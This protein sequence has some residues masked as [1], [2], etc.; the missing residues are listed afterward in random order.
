MI[1]FSNLVCMKLKYFFFYL[2][3]N[4]KIFFQ[5]RNIKE[6]ENVGMIESFCQ[7]KKIGKDIKWN[8]QLIQLSERFY[9]LYIWFFFNCVKILNFGYFKEIFLSVIYCIFVFIL[10]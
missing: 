7:K 9:L 4:L 6:K 10:L 2:Y 3:C 1:I 8:S 5:V